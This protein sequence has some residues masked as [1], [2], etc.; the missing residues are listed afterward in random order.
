MR[1][2]LILLL[3]AAP[4]FAAPPVV[5]VPAE[6]RGEP[7]AFIVVRADTDAAAV[8]FY[9]VDPGLNVFP[10]G[11]LSDPYATVVTSA[12]PGRFRLLAFSGNADGPSD[13]VEVLI[14]IGQPGPGPGPTPPPGPEP[15]PD[16]TPVPTPGKRSVA[17]VWESSESTPEIA[18][19]ITAFRDGPARAYLN[20]KRHLLSLIDDDAVDGDGKPAA[21]LE[22]WRPHFAGM[23]LPAFFIIDSTGKLLHKQEVAPGTTADNLIELIKRHGG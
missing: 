5:K 2:L 6:V 11:L 13:P 12:R 1:A 22:A 8:K 10:S 4:L 3:L 15:E 17:I 7:A 18:R 16:P 23:R 21:E 20:S 14:V 9:A 19:L